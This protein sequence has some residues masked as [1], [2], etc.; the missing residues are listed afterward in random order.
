MIEKI[1]GADME[2]LLD[3]G[4]QAGEAN[5]AAFGDMLLAKRRGGAGSSE[6]V[7]TDQPSSDPVKEGRSLLAEGNRLVDEGMDLLTLGAKAEAMRLLRAGAERQRRGT[8]LLAQGGDKDDKESGQPGEPSPSELSGQ[9]TQG[10]RPV[11]VAVEGSLSLH[12]ARLAIYYTCGLRSPREYGTVVTPVVKATGSMALRP[13]VAALAYA[14]TGTEQFFDAPSA[15][16]SFAA[17]GG[18]LARKAGKSKQFSYKFNY[19]RHH[20]F[21]GM[22]GERAFSDDYNATVSYGFK[23]KRHKMTL[24]PLLEVTGRRADVP[25]Q[26]R[27]TFNEGMKLLLIVRPGARVFVFVNDA[28]REVIL[29]ASV[30]RNRP[31]RNSKS[32]HC[33]IRKDKSPAWWVGNTTGI[34]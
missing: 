34:W 22:F 18:M 8:L 17:I 7:E 2:V 32:R 16:C 23:N 1:S 6:S 3:S 12:Y 29:N 4:Q 31:I 9:P 10:S 19:E 5:G 26:E 33:I 20:A 21:D 13:N 14:R 11:K 27:V 30:G 25:A 15:S 28:R 24:R